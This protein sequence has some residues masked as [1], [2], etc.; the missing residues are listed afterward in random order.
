[1]IGGGGG[2]RS[3]GHRCEELPPVACE[4]CR[5]LGL[6]ARAARLFARGA[7][8]I[9]PSCT[10]PIRLEQELNF[11]STLGISKWRGD[12]FIAVLTG[13]AMGFPFSMMY[14]TSTL[15]GPFATFFA[16]W[17]VFAGSENESPCFS[18][19]GACPSTESSRAPSR[20]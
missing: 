1:M 13:V 20:M 2:N 9:C 10:K 3:R 18:V 11:G 12:H 6:I 5:S 4:C 16:Q 15:V 14:V 7:Q 17:T 19:L 8:E